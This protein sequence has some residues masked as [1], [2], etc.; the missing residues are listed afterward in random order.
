[1]VV[2]TESTRT[3]QYL[4]SLL[5]EEG[6]G[7]IPFNGSNSSKIASE[8]FEKWK[9]EFPE[10]ATELSRPTA[11]RQALVHEFRTNPNKKVF[12][13]TEA[14]SEGL[15]LQF[16]NLLINYDLPWNPQRVEQRIGRVHRY[17]QKHE[18]IIANLLNTKNHADKRVLEL[19]TE[20]LG[21]FDGLF[22]SSDEILG[23]IESGID[24]EQR[25]LGVYQKCKTPEE[26]DKA[27]NKLQEG[28]K[29]S[30]SADMQNLL[31]GQV[32]TDRPRFSRNTI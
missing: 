20:K 23:S 2:F 31:W 22:G 10:L 32:K 19:L 30:V 4:E 26:I 5:K 6:L 11:I 15:N 13:T 24:F 17:G 27:F 14:G 25:V 12:L 7:H 3:Q 16:A 8:A 21:L 28:L 29:E 9:H 18:V 1:V